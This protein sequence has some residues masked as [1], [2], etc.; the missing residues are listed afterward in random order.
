SERASA[1]Q[2]SK[3]ARTAA[4][5]D[6]SSTMTKRHGWALPTDGACTARPMSARIASLSTGVGRKRRTS[7]RQ[8]TS[9]AK[10]ARQ[11]AS[12]T[13]G[14]GPPVPWP[15][16]ATGEIAEQARRHRQLRQRQPGGGDGLDGAADARDL[17]AAA[18]LPGLDGLRP[19]A[20][21]DDLRRQAAVGIGQAV[22]GPVERE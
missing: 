2:R 20:V 5:R 6:G 3:L 13:G 18:L 14:A 10:H 7:R 12:N 8:A 17:A 16:S 1:L 21:G 11:A 4:R 19:G 15:A 22:D 9:S